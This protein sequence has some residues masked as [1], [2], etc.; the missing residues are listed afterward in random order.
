[1]EANRI[2]STDRRNRVHPPND[3]LAGL[4]R[5]GYYACNLGPLRSADLLSL[6]RDLQRLGENLV[7]GPVVDLKYL[8]GSPHVTLTRSAVPFHNDGAYRRVP[9][10]YLVLYCKIPPSRGGDT[11]LVRGDKA[12]LRL[13][14]STRNILKKRLFHITLE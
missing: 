9:P 13:D 1:M 14:P 2:M 4:C 6:A 5:D 7:P 8:R 3:W 12:V 11:L 10:R